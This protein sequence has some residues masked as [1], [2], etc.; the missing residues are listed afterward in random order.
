MD[1]V[2]GNKKIKIPNTDIEK[3]MSVLGLTKE[4]AI[5]LWLDDNDYT[6]NEEQEA[7]DKK[8]K[9]S[10]IT[11]TIHKASGID[12]TIK[13]TQKERCKKENPTKEKV[14][15]ETA[16]LLQSFAENVKI[17][18]VTKLITFEMNG[19]HFEFDLKQ[20]RKKK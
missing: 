13:K 4:D 5:Q 10:K 17:E 15:S 20:K 19:E 8:A 14:I 16:K 7:L 9:D 11:S 3:F 6:K 18:N 12:K 2:L 1:Y